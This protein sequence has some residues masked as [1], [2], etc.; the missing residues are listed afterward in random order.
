[1][2]FDHDALPPDLPRDLGLPP[3][4]GGAG[5]ELMELT[6]ADGTVFSAALAQA[7]QPIAQGGA[8][9]ILPDIRGLYR[10][11]LALAERFAAA[12]HH[13]I[14][15]DLY[16]R[17]AGTGLRGEDFDGMG[18]AAATETAQVQADVAAAAA[19][20][21]ERTGHDGDVVSVGF[22]FGGSMSLLCAAN[23]QLDLQGV[24][25]FYGGLNGSRLGFT[26]PL[27]LADRMRGPILGLYG[28]EDPSIPPAAVEDLDA[29]L[30]DA[31]VDHE[32]VVYPGA[33]HS[34]F[35]RQA[36][37]FADASADAWRRVL[38]FLGGVSARATA[39]V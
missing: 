36:T 32:I 16:G 6:S 37:D 2:C 28:G 14:V 18:Q 22:C 7:P 17:T 25:A 19:A 23:P 5:A 30:G 1:M 3:I 4:A 38:G 24:V 27:E 34:F 33:P 10:F 29:R 31:G 11:Y 13:A 9:V 39:G 12:G 35:D 26:S 21:R 15:V 20:L 8:V